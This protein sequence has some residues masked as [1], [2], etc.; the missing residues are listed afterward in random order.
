VTVTWWNDRAGVPG[1]LVLLGLIALPSSGLAQS[2]VPDLSQMSIE[3]LLN[4]EITSAGRKEQRAADA[5]A[6]VFVITQEDIRRSGMTSIPDLLRLAPG[7]QVAQLNS[8]KWAVT[9]RGFNGLYANKL[10]VL[11]D[12]RSVYNRIFSGVLWDAEDLVLDDIDRI[13]VIR[14]P[15]AALWGANAVNGVINIVTKGTADTQGLLLRVGGGRADDQG[16]IR[17]GGS[18]GPTRYRLYAQWT[19]RHQSLITPDARADDASHSVTTGFRA[20]WTTRPGAFTLQGAFT[21]GKVR[22][23]WPNLDPQ[24]AAREPRS[25]DPTETRDGHVLGRWTYTRAGGATFQVQS[26]VNAGGRE[27]P[28]GSYHRHSVD[29]DTQYHAALGAHQDLVAGA[30]Y[31]F[32]RDTF[33][34]H[35]GF[36]LTPVENNWSRVTAFIQDEIDLFGSRLAVTL[37][38]QV[39][40]DSDS[41]TGVQPTARVM[42]KALPRQRLWAATSRALRSPS[43][44]ERGIRVDFPPVPS[45]SGPPLVVSFRGN[46]AA[47]TETLVDAEAG[48]R[49][50]IGS[51]ASIDVTGFVGRYDHLRTLEQAAPVVRFV[52]SPQTL[53]T[54]EFGNRLEATTR[55]LEVAGHW[56][57]ARAWR[58]DASYSAFH[59]TPRLAAGSLDPAAAQEDGSAPRR[60][61]QVRSAFSP[62]T[63]ATLNLAIFHVG[64]LEQSHVDAYAR[65]DV[66]AE[67]RFTR[68][69]SAMAIGQNLFDAAHVESAGGGSLLLT[70]Q[71]PRSASVRLRWTFP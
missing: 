19:G 65:A 51:A 9:V 67:W 20:D 22:A 13:E 16:T 5:A 29:V 42:W 64:P 14:G 36:S 38:S 34:G 4:I 27:E 28:V 63:R 21:A 60:Q 52:P 47:R 12:G 18:L 68:R 45:P 15:G 23:L 44:Y 46:P 25:L 49:L 41:G 71:V 7:V 40:H 54:A 57:P 35:T 56:S 37:G 33:A 17:Y 1:L 69:L 8:N 11:V 48:Y 58:F 2:R 10:L 70:T 50:E 55:G 32:S 3:D 24:T 31:R 43:L 53:V 61:W 30:G 6:A 59:L 39:Q 26:F 62:G 66:S